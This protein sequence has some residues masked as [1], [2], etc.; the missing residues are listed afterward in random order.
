MSEWVAVLGAGKDQLEILRAV[1]R[2]DCL[3]KK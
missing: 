3:Q 2:V 1:R